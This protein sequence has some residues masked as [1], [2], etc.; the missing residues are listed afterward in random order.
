MTDPFT[1]YQS[2]PGTALPSKRVA[3]FEPMTFLENLEIDADG[4]LTV[5]SLLDGRLWSVPFGAPARLLCQ[6]P[7]RGYSVAAATDRGWL[8]F[9]TK[10]GGGVVVF[11]VLPEGSSRIFVELPD[12]VFPN[13]VQRFPD[14]HY[15]LADSVTATIWDI[16]YPSGGVVVWYRHPSLAPAPGRWMPA[17]NGLKSFADHLY[18][19]NSSTAQILKLRLKGAAPDGDIEVVARDVS[20]DDFAFA[21][22]GSM[23]ITT[24][25]MDVVLRLTSDGSLSRVASADQGV[26]GCTACRF[27]RAPG[28]ETGLYV[29][30][31]G[32]LFNPASGGLR[33]AQVMRLETGVRGA[34]V[35]LN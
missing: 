8:V 17:L 20:G 13:G 15:L 3:E 35:D 22:D 4:T 33:P 19:T 1:Y 32:G 25:P 34:P 31:D 5:T 28:D 29:V 26:R 10:L 2:I 18:M 21:V 6:L 16:H 27:G 30:A 7:G 12:A 14:G 9:G 23:F 11:H 24:H